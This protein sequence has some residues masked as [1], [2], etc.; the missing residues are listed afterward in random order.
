MPD[1]QFA[2]QEDRPS[3]L[4]ADLLRAAA[5]S[6]TA[7]RREL[8][9]PR[10]CRRRRTP[11]ADDYAQ[12]AAGVRTGA[13]AAV[14]SGSGRSAAAAAG[15]RRD[16]VAVRRRGAA[17]VRGA[18]LSKRAKQAL[19][20]GDRAGALRIVPRRLRTARPA[21]RAHPAAAAGPP[22]DAVGRVGRRR[23]RRVAA[24]ARRR[25]ARLGRRGPVGRRPA[26][27]G[28]DQQAPVA[29]PAGLP[30]T[31]SQ[32]GARRCCAKPATMVEEST[33]DEELKRQLLSRIEHEPAPRRRSTSRTTRP[34]W[35]STP[36][37]RRFSTRSSASAVVKIEVQQRMAEMV[38]QFNKLVD[39]H[40]YAEAE[41][42]ANRL[43]EMAPDELVAQQV[44]KQAKMI[45]REQLSRRHQRRSRKRAWRTRMLGHSRR[46][47]ADALGEL[48]RGLRATATDWDDDQEPQGVDRSSTRA[49]ASRSSRSSRSSRRRC[50]RS[51]TKR[52]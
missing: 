32:P 21:R 50:C 13:D 38:D 44:N 16:A 28:R 6:Q 14:R 25:D 11:G 36:R 33:L 17:G 12:A 37:T 26:T 7:G 51:T 39:E 31:G 22:A 49:A 27:F 41:V 40:R 15:R 43:Y 19:K 47:A 34:S 24:D 30:R 18:W 35:S 52:R 20:A 29:R 4:A 42:V 46:T 2:P 8:P 9:S 3:R 48:E 10:P 1:S 23:R 45:R 5:E